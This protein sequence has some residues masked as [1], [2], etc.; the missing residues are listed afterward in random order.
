MVLAYLLPMTKGKHDALRAAIAE[1]RDGKTPD[2]S[3]F[4]DLL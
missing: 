3:G 2:E 1:K 4:K